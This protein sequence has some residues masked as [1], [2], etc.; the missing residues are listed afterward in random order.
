MQYYRGEMN[1]RVTHNV[2]VQVFNVCMQVF[3]VY[4]TT[5]PPILPP[6]DLFSMVY[7]CNS[8]LLNLAANT[9]NKVHFRQRNN[10]IIRE[11]V[12]YACER[13]ENEIT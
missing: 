3:N 8:N 7:R 10:I 9:V 6:T 4:H 1:Q 5:R 2:Y 13:T 11:A 12:A